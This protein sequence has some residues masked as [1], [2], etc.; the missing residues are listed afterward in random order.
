MARCH[1][2]LCCKLL[3]HTP[4]KLTLGSCRHQ[5]AA[6]ALPAWS[7]GDSQGCWN[8]GAGSTGVH[9]KRG[10]QHPSWS[11]SFSHSAL[12]A[13]VKTW[14]RWTK[15]KAHSPFRSPPPRGWRAEPIAESCYTSQPHFLFS[16]FVLKDIKILCLKDW[17]PPTQSKPPLSKIFSLKKKQ[18]M[19]LQM[20][21]LLP[22]K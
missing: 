5:L 2:L 14:A 6:P 19:K 20:K 1:H 3:T 16:F 4:C 22:K 10:I 11:G 8:S 21:L 9:V 15:P 12:E 18:N 17:P 13:R 7:D